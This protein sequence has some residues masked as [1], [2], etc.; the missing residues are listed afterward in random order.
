MAVGTVEMNLRRRRV[1]IVASSTLVVL[2][3]AGAAF[4]YWSTTGAGTGTAG[5]GTNAAV[6]ITQTSAI[7]G[8][9]PG[10]PASAI[11]FS[12]TNPG[13]GP[14]TIAA[15]AITVSSVTKALGAPAG[16]CDATDFTITAPTFAA[17]AI[18]AG[19]TTPFTGASTGA[20]IVMVNKVATNQDACKGA[21]VNLA[22]AAS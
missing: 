19:A 12:V 20:Q 16:T 6:T 4:A 8:L 21:T 1:A 22:Y 11:D 15:V 17:T 9:V 5:V 3:G 13:T 2:V 14:E 7:S 18:A 10:G